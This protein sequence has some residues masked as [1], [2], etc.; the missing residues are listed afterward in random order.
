MFYT[1]PASQNPAIYY[2]KKKEA[3]SKL[4][5]SGFLM[6]S[7][8]LTSLC[9]VRVEDFEVWFVVLGFRKNTNQQARR[10][11]HLILRMCMSQT[12]SNSRHQFCHCLSFNVVKMHWQ[13]CNQNWNEVSI[14]SGKK[15]NAY[16]KPTW[17]SVKNIFVHRNL[18]LTWVSA[19]LCLNHSDFISC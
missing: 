13:V 14:A 17:N 19:Y 10:H 15:I 8:Y 5:T 4:R 2:C 7:E 16:E 12:L 6:K 3:S 18:T 11:Y 9:K 1:L